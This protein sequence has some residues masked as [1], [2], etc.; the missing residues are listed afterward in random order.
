M[1]WLLIC[2]LVGYV[3]A[4]RDNEY[5]GACSM[6]VNAA[7]AEAVR[8]VVGTFIDPPSFRVSGSIALAD[9]VLCSDERA[10]GPVS[11]LVAVRRGQCGFQKKVEVAE[12]AGYQGAY[13]LTS[14]CRTCRTCRTCHT[15][16]QIPPSPFVPLTL[17]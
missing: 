3:V 6:A 14:T 13:M 12:A 1:R 9:D 8:C 10:F 11:Q 17:H 5:L 7:A 4:Y 16:A 15:A 2:I